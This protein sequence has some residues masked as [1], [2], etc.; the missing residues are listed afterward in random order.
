MEEIPPP[1]PR[2]KHPKK[3]RKPSSS[4]SSSSRPVQTSLT[5]HPSHLYLHLSLHRPPTSTSALLDASTA[6]L[7]LLAA[8][9]QYLGDHG[10]AVPVDVLALRAEQ[11]DVVVRVP[12]ADGVAVVAAL[13]GWVGADVAG[14]GGVAWR[15]RGKGEWLAGVS[16]AGDGQRLFDFGM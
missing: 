12:A 16:A 4:S 5:L 9:T 10:A 2:P 15:V 8:L 13:A 3:K 7:H 6:R 1:P 11:A 14:G